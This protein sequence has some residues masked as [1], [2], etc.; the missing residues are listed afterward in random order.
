M[1]V[2]SVSRTSIAGDG[3]SRSLIA[4]SPAE[5]LGG[6]QLVT[7]TSIAYSGTS[8]SIGANGSVEFSAVTSLSLNGVFTGDYDNYMVVVRFLGTTGN[9]GLF[10]RLRTSGTDASGTDYTFQRL[11][12]ESTTVNGARTSSANYARLSSTNNGV[13]HGFTTNI[14]GPYLAQPTAYRTVT[15]EGEGGAR[16]LDYAGTH[17]LSTSYDGLTVYPEVS[18]SSTFSGLVSVYGLVGA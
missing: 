9:V 6:M 5:E 4:V 11:L 17:G 15:V 12:A 16:M 13:Y 8:A 14:Y 2:V 1:A 3:R 10:A 7:P 18:V